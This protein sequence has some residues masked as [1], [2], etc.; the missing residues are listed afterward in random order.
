MSDFFRNVPNEAVL[1][2]DTLSGLL[3]DLREDR[4]RVLAE[5][6]ADSEQQLLGRI[7]TGEV[8]EHPAYEHYLAAKILAETR[9]TVREQLSGLL[10]TGIRRC[11][12]SN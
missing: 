3:Y 8:D 12:I 7:V 2:I 11:C 6:R 4:K 9:E 1:Q 10:A 5:Y